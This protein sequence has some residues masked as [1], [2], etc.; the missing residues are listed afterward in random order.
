MKNQL[1]NPK[2]KDDVLSTLLANGSMYIR[3][4]INIPSDE[5]DVSPD[6]LEA[7][8]D[9]FERMGLISQ[10]KMIGGNIDIRIKAEAHDL[11]S[12]G[13]FV[14]QEEI[15]RAN[16]EKLGFELDK[17]SKDLS[18]DLLDKANK[19]SGISSAILSALSLFKS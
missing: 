9:Q 1:I 15:L 4:N 13:G 14:A 18:P 12:H 8:L 11:Y 5:L 17:L 6:I 16:I 7:I 19:L 3:C 10:T 2:L